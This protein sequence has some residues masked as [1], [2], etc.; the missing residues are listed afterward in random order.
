[1]LKTLRKIRKENQIT[2]YDM[3]EYLGITPSFYSQIENEKRR[4]FYDTAIKIAYFFDMTPKELFEQNERK[5]SS[6][7][8]SNH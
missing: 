1:M 8:V 3:A 5:D 6:Y 2:I 7:Y 4:L